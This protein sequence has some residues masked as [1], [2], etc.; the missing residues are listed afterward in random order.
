MKN[1]KLAIDVGHI[2]YQKVIEF[3][4]SKSCKHINVPGAL[5][6]VRFLFGFK[7]IKIQYCTLGKKKYTIKYIF[8]STVFQR[9]KFLSFQSVLLLGCV[10]FGKFWLFCTERVWFYAKKIGSLAV[11]FL[12][13]KCYGFQRKVNRIKW[14]FS[15]LIL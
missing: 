12:R 11:Q 6:Y 13:Q 7:I 4:R 9:V 10:R 1:I 14:S 2:K 3:D 5:F 15:L 8:S